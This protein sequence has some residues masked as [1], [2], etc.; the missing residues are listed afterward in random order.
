MVQRHLQDPPRKGRSH[1]LRAEEALDQLAR[2]GGQQKAEIV[3]SSEEIN[4][5]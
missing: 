3:W 1:S 2:L 4:Q 5:H